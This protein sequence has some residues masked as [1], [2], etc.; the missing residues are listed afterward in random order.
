M[1]VRVIMY[2]LISL[3]VV[4]SFLA[5]GIGVLMPAQGGFKKISKFVCVPMTFD[6]DSKM[7]A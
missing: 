5:I 3:D 6:I 7:A 2:A 4:V 1:R